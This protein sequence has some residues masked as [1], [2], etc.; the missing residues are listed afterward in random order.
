MGP[1][2]PA[3][4]CRNPWLTNSKPSVNQRAATR[5]PPCPSGAAAAP[6]PIIGLAN[7]GA[8]RKRACGSSRSPSG[9]L[10][11]CFCRWPPMLSVPFLTAALTPL[12]GRANA[13]YAEIFI[14]LVAVEHRGRGG[15]GD[16]ARNRA[17]ARAGRRHASTPS[18][19]PSLI[20]RRRCRR[21]AAKSRACVAATDRLADVLGERQRRELVHND[22]DRT[23]QAARRVNLSNLARQ[24]EIGDRSRH[25]ADRRRRR[26]LAFQGRGHAGGARNR[27]GGFRRDR[28]RRRR[29]A[30]HEPGRRPI[31][32]PGDAG[33]RRDIR[34][35][36]A[37][38][39]AGPRSGRRAPMPRARPSMRWPRRPTRSATSSP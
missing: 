13:A 3:P 26:D 7:V 17:A 2:G 36:A 25:P 19:M 15:P 9:L 31:V 20:P 32:R 29:L 12:L 21:A 30:R 24:V 23:W 28:A 16:R 37:R 10:R 6:I 34:A 39:R 8:S 14:G 33:D 38:Q 35:G 11:P 18:P 4:G 22:L 1:G 5:I 27:A